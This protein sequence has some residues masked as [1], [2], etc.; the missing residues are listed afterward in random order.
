MTIEKVNKPE[1]VAKKKKNSFHQSHR[2]RAPHF[3]HTEEKPLISTITYP[4]GLPIVEKREAIVQAIREHQVVVITGDTGSGK[5]TQIPKMCMEAGRG[6]RGKIGCTQPRRVA[7]VSVA[8]RVMEELGAEGEMLVG[9]Q[10]RFQ[11]RT[12]H[13]TRIKFMTDGI[14]LAETQG[15]PLLSNYDTLSIDEAHERSLN[16]DFLLGI[17][18]QLL[19][20]RQDLKVIITSAT[21]DT[22]KFSQS[23]DHAP[24]IEV[25]G[26]MYPVEVWY[27]PIDHELED[28]GDIT[29]IDQAVSA[30]EELK[31]QRRQGDILIFM[32]TERDIRETQQ[33]LEGRQY[34]R[35]VILPLFGRLTTDEQTRVFQ[36]LSEQKIVVATNVA[37]TSITIPGIKYVI[38]TGMAR[39]SQ[40]NARTRTQSLPIQSISQSSADQRKGR[41]GRVESG[42]CIRLYAEEEYLEWPQFTLPEIKRSNLARVILQMVFLKLGNVA[43][44]P[45]IDPPSPAAIKD[46]YGALRELEALDAQ[47]QLSDVGMMMARLPLDPRIARMLIEA[48]K[49]G[50]IREVAVIAAA[51][52][53]QDPRE[54]PMELEAKADEMHSR[55]K[56]PKSDFLTFLKIWN[57]YHETWE[58]FKTQNQMRKF[59]KTHFLSFNRMREWQ[60]IHEQ[61]LTILDELGEYLSVGRQI[62]LGDKRTGR[63]ASPRPPVPP[64]PVFEA[65]HLSVLSGLLSHVALRIEENPKEKNLYRTSRGREVMIF[66][67]SGQFGQAGQ[68]IVA[69][70]LVRTSRL[71][72]RVVATIQPEWLESLAANLCRKSYSDPH[73][74]K[75][76][77]QVV[78]LERVSLFGLI[79]VAGR[80]ANYGPIR[81]DEAREIFIRSALVENDIK[82]KFSF[83]EHNQRLITHIEEWEDKTRRRDMLVDDETL[84]QFYAERIT[85][86]ISDV[87]TFI[88]WLK[89]RGGDTFLQMRPEDLLRIAPDEEA[90]SQFPDTLRI[91][92][93]AFS[94]TYKFE[95]GHEEDG[96]TLHIPAHLLTQI[97]P[98]ALEWLVPGLLPEKI[99]LLLKGLPKAYRKQ[100]IPLQQTAQVLCEQLMSCSKGAD[101]IFAAKAG[102]T[103]YAAKG[104]VASHAAKDA[105]TFSASNSASKGSATSCAAK[106]GN[107]FSSALTSALTSALKGAAALHAAKG[108]SSASS[109]PFLYQ[110]SLYEALERIIQKEYG[111]QIP[112]SAW[113]EA[114]LPPHLR[115]R[116]AVLDP[117]GKV[118]GQGRELVSLIK[119]APR[120]QEDNQWKDACRK[121]ER[122]SLTNW[123]FENLPKE[124]LLN[125]GSTGETAP[126]RLAYPGLVAAKDAV[127]DNDSVSIRLFPT[128]QMAA[129]ATRKGLLTLYAIQYKGDLKQ[130]KKNWELPMPQG[131]SA[132]WKRFHQDFGD[133]QAFHEV[134]FTRILQG[135]FPVQDGRIPAKKEFYDQLE[136]VR[137][138]LA[139]KGRQI[140]EKIQDLLMDWQTTLD[141]V[142]RFRRLAVGNSLLNQLL[143]EIDAEVSLLLPSDFLTSYAMDRLTEIPRYLKAIRIRA[144]RAYA[145]PQ[146]DQAKAQQLT[147][148]LARLKGAMETLDHGASPQKAEQIEEYRWMIEEFKISTF[149]PEVG[150]AYPVSAKRLEK[151]WEEISGRG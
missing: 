95:P 45:F 117:Q 24:I 139:L 105:D 62:G 144:E 9:Y 100:L 128:Q 83:L 112:R 16:I 50:V 122:D 150:T 52:S 130:L 58:K 22:E 56:E 103:S 61:I 99:A 81:P 51:L 68:W 69:A 7:A 118:L 102:D 73:W 138:R 46:G 142:A 93:I 113:S 123:D 43:V 40:Y 42:I 14:L 4:A 67:G 63:Q 13:K 6:L 92:D 98:Q 149:A 147:T 145:S 137:G 41:C 71:F 80:K 141:I 77:G 101:K 124:I 5:T 8:K 104:G 107:A 134:L 29:Y 120:Q 18:R 74:E 55:F 97:S 90:I 116:L 70:E 32:P 129:R 126:P 60:D 59:C 25:S 119:T 111:L 121:W 38:D 23:F 47:N 125:P 26:R 39:V 31:K 65:I 3:V 94:L 30:V 135:I 54:R 82:E 49:E 136:Q 34:Q 115:L 75:D 11:D 146:K 10:I 15:D 44:F 19:P 84:Y 1:V 76:R 151:K 143:K 91:G 35:T 148:H 72:A 48:K 86:P 2:Q 106:G 88:R 66:P 28:V 140:M 53:V 27:R 20:R 87:R 127:L 78:A 132:T 33:R 133:R 108:A 131:L 96:A 64:S 57:D 37:E 109:A 85:E 110:G 12:S 114:D 36:S 17:L 79:I 89:D 21:I